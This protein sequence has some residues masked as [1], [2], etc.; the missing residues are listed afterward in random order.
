MT[1]HTL[2]HEDILGLYMYTA[3]FLNAIS[4]QPIAGLIHARYLIN[5][6]IKIINFSTAYKGLLV[7]VGASLIPIHNFFSGSF[8]QNTAYLFMGLAIGYYWMAFEKNFIRQYTRSFL[9]KNKKLIVK[10]NLGSLISNAVMEPTGLQLSSNKDKTKRRESGLRRGSN[11]MTMNNDAYHFS[12]FSLICTALFEELLY[13]GFLLAMCL[14][15]HQS[16]FAILA[17]LIVTITFSFS[18][19]NFGRLQVLLKMLFSFCMLASVLVTGNLIPAIFAHVVFNILAWQHLKG[20][21]VVNTRHSA[22]QIAVL[23]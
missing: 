20:E 7:L 4:C 3:F 8:L 21:T 9:L 1:P 12:L 18:H 6:G 19:Y 10:N 5:K 23:G 13:R 2:I 14:R 16:I 15:L 17:T 11:N 22:Q